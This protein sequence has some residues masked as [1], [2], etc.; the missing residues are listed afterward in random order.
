VDYIFVYIREKLQ[1]Q[2]VEIVN[3]SVFPK[4]SK[5]TVLAVVIVSTVC[6]YVNTREKAITD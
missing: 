5:A 2:E 3:S 6:V 1:E 4:S